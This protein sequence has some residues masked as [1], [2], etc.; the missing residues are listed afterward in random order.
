MK[1][2]NSNSVYNNSS[3]NQTQ[4]NIYLFKFRNRNTKSQQ[5]KHQN[6]VFLVF[7]LLTL[8]K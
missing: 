4:G 7:L 3:F 8:I 2:G 5:Q 1:N 6:D